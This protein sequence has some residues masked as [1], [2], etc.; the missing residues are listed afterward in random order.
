MHPDMDSLG[1]HLA[2]VSGLQVRRHEPLAEHTSWGVGG[3]ADLYVIPYTGA[4]L[5]SAWRGLQTSGVDYFLLGCGTNLLVSDAGVRGVVVSL[6]PGLGGVEVVGQRLLAMAGATLGKL[7]HVAAEAGLSG[8]ECLAGI[9]GTVGGALYMNAGANG[10]CVGDLVVAVTV[11]DERGKRVT[12]AREEL[13]FGYRSSSFCERRWCV[14][15]AAF[16]L[17]PSDARVVHQRIYEVLQR[18]CERQ[19]LGARSAGSVFKR[20]PGD[21]AGRLL[22]A[23]GAKGLRVGGAQVSRKHANFI[24]NT[25]AATAADIV[26]LIRLARRRVYERFGIWLDTEVCLAGEGMSGVAAELG[27]RYV[28][29]TSEPL[30]LSGC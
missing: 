14:V 22:E 18:R 30:K 27:T 21:Y 11:L 24:L 25:G 12:L 20:P 1:R 3:P 13:E 15:E 23:V 17:V 29:A 9:P 19:P 26:A 6:Y 16:G 5:A 28:S 10:T 4:A 8:L 2:S 7:C